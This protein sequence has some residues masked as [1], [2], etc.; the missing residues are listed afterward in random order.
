MNAVKAVLGCLMALGESVDQA[1]Q[2]DGKFTWTD[3]FFLVKPL[4][5][6]PDAYVQAKQAEQEWKHSTPEQRAEV[7]QWIKDN[8]K[9]SQKNA[10]TE[11][12]VEAALAIVVNANEFFNA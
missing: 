12:H 1:K 6:A 10:K 4:S 2:N 8:F 5:L 7:I 9:L 3:I 11:K